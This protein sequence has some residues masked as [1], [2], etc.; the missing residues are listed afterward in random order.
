MCRNWLNK[1]KPNFH[2]IHWMNFLSEFGFQFEQEP[3]NF[4]IG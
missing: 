2:Q 4:I 3:S 1:L